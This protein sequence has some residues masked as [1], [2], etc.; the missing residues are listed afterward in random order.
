MLRGFSTS[1]C[2]SSASESVEV[3]VLLMIF[4]SVFSQL[5]EF[6]C[7]FSKL[8]SNIIPSQ[9]WCQIPVTSVTPEAEGGLLVQ[10][11]PQ[12]ELVQG[13]PWLLS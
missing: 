4:L 11:R 2:S 1:Q 9:V 7:R 10:L 13:Q 12:S 8:E 6:S 5:Q 3:Y